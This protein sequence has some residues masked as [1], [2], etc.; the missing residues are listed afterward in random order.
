MDLWRNLFDEA[1]IRA[2][3]AETSLIDWKRPYREA[4]VNEWLPTRLGEGTVT[5]AVN[6]L[7]SPFAG[8][9][10]KALPIPGRWLRGAVLPD[11]PIIAEGGQF[12]VGTQGY[13]YDRLG[14]RRLNR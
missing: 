4:L 5:A 3:L 1:A 8:Q 7:V 10:I 11:E 9:E 2:Q 12:R 14:T 13:I 6:G